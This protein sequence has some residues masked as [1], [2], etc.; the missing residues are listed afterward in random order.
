MADRTVISPIAA[1]T[2]YDADGTAITFTASDS[3][4]G[5]TVAISSTYTMVIARNDG[6]SA[7][8]LV[9]D[10]VA[11]K[12]LGN[13]KGDITLTLAAGAYAMALVP[14]IG[15]RQTGN[16]LH[17]DAGGTGAADVDIC[18]FPWR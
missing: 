2:P 17:L 12:A 14:T 5:N 6:A 10:S 8:T 18:A 16:V 1:P 9:I 15:F 13:R 3:V 4:N 11:T 7:A